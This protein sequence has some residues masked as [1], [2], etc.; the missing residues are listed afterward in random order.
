VIHRLDERASLALELFAAMQGVERPS[1]RGARP[2]AQYRD[3]EA[4]EEEAND[5]E[6][7]RV[8]GFTTPAGGVE[9]AA[10]IVA[11]MVASSAGPNPPNTALAATGTVRKRSGPWTPKAGI[12]NLSAATNAVK[13]T[14]M[15]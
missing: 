2:S 14:A 15:P 10:M 9:Y 13:T 12:A 4:L 3:D 5:V 8:P 11:P 1:Q 7:V 6:A